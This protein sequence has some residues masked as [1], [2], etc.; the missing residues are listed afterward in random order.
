MHIAKEDKRIGDANY[1]RRTCKD[2]EGKGIV[3]MAIKQ[4]IKWGF[5]DS[6]IEA[7]GIKHELK[8]IDIR[9]AK[10]NDMSIKLAECVLKEFYG[11]GPVYNDPIKCYLTGCDCPAVKFIILPKSNKAIS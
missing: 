6:T 2:L 3:T 9:V 1:W 10:C 5:G 8:E 7:P 11:Y 4:L